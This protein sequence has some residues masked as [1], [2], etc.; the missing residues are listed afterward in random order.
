MEW[1]NI[2][3]I[4]TMLYGD[5]NDKNWEKT[6]T[7]LRLRFTSNLIKLMVE[8]KFKKATSFVK[9]LIIGGYNFIYRLHLEKDSDVIVRVP[10]PHLAEF[11]I[12]K[13]LREIA[14]VKYIA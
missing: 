11:P 3:K 7:N 14:T 10:Y 1:P 12:E 2:D 8:E 13:T 9:P 6:A 4:L 5:R